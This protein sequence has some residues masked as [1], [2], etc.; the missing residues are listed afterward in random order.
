MS[1]IKMVPSLLLHIFENILEGLVGSEVGGIISLSVELNIFFYLIAEETPLFRDFFIRRSLLCL[2]RFGDR[3][4]DKAFINEIREV[5]V[6][7]NL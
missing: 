6:S 1:L 7:Y 2:L 5:I 3:K 4:V